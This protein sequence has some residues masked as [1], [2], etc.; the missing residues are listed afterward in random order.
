[1][2]LADD[3]RNWV[4]VRKP[5]R[6][7]VLGSARRFGLQRSR[8]VIETAAQELLHDASIYDAALIDGE[9]F[10]DAV[11]E[12]LIARL[13]DVCARALLLW[14]PADRKL[15]ARALG[16]TQLHDYGEG[17]LYGYEIAT[18]KTPPDWLNPG[19]WANP[20]MWDKKRW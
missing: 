19:Y 12:P 17:V 8:G 4:A 11:L 16:L 15:N 6:I 7:V 1:M 3:V 14:L 2:A 18:Y 13:R 9:R 5:A 10:D 20:Q